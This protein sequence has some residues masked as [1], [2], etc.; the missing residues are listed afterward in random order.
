MNNKEKAVLSELVRVIDAI[1][2]NEHIDLG[3][4]IYN[5]REREGKGWDG[6]SVHAWG[7]AVTDLKIVL[8][9]AKTPLEDK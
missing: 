4:L 7:Q 6:P 2:D 8:A 1:N 5:V 3:D 9:N